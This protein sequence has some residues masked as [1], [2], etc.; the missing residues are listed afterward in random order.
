[1]LGIAPE[2]RGE[3]VQNGKIDFNGLLTWVVNIEELPTC[4]S[5]LATVPATPAHHRPGVAGVVRVVPTHLYRVVAWYNANLADL[6]I[7][8]ML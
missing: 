1:M 6:K 7:I 5:G 2:K 4:Y 3:K 8:T